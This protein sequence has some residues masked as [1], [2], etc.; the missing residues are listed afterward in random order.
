M[1]QLFTTEE[2]AKYLAVTP[3]RVRQFIGENR[4][5]SVKHGRDHLIEES[6]VKRFA[7]EGKKKRG[8]PERK[9]NK[10]LRKR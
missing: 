3:S 8:R 4:L 5:R 1:G 2:A 7:E 10:T 9:N 6:E